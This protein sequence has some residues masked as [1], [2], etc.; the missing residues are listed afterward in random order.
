MGYSH[1]DVV[2]MFANGQTNKNGSR[3][4]SRNETLYSHGRHFPL[5]VKRDKASNLK[6]K[7]AWHLLNGDR[8]SISTSAH[9]HYT[10]S[11]FPHSPRVSFTAIAGA[12]LDPYTC[13][14]VDWQD[15][16]QGWS[17]PGDADFETFEQTA[18]MGAMVTVDRKDGEIT[19]K[20]YHRIG[21]AVL[22]DPR[23]GK[24][25]LCS[26]DEGSYFVSR[27]PRR[28]KSLG[29]AFQAL[30]PKRAQ[31][32]M[33]AGIDVKRQGEWFC[34]PV[35]KLPYGV[36]K[37]HMRHPFELPKTDARSNTHLCTAGIT[38]AK[39]HYIMGR[40]RHVFWG[41]QEGWLPTREHRTLK[42]DKGLVYE[43]VRNTSLGDWSSSGRVD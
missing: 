22:R 17:Y 15:D 33:A 21:G 16:A 11:A 30:V 18:P 27:L 9:Q 1:R 19:H 25:H 24:D 42:L 12:D 37:S 26:M 32:A 4:F 3:V 7:E 43:A 23:T 20:S 28:V 39:R 34:I 2:R 35:D 6:T 31:E 5:A 14:V 36:R 8:F 40:I 10:F 13:L 38:H 41:W 29:D